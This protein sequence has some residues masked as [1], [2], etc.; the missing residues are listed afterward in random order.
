M[1]SHSIGLKGVCR[2][3]GNFYRIRVQGQ[4]FQQTRV[5]PILK[6]LAVFWGE[7]VVGRASSTSMLGGFLLACSINKELW[8]ESRNGITAQ[9][10]DPGKASGELALSKLDV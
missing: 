6:T 3:V 1:E 9:K 2:T 10:G 7:G 8:H 4:S 5:R